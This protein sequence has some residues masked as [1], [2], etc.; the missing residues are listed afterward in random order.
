MASS[1]S[2]EKAIKIAILAV[3]SV[4]FLA[5]FTYAFNSLFEYVDEGYRLAL[6]PF[7]T[8]EGKPKAE[9]Y[10]TLL[11]ISAQREAAMFRLVTL[12]LA[13][14][15]AFAGLASVLVR[16]FSPEPSESKL[17]LAT[18]PLLLLALG[19][20]LLLLLPPPPPAQAAPEKPGAPASPL[21][22]G[23]SQTQ[24]NPP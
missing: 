18:S 20:T 12:A 4:I 22:S 10:Q 14:G 24:S 13:L 1:P 9:D 19:A 21:L 8:A 16:P 23:D 11:A 15:C 2:N 7:K 17:S 5:A 6:A 3:V